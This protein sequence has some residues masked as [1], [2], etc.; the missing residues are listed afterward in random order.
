M[1]DVGHVQFYNMTS[2]TMTIT[3]NSGN[4]KINL[5]PKDQKAPAYTPA[6]SGETIARSTNPEPYQQA[7]F[8]IKN[9]I[10]W[11]LSGQG[12]TKDITIAVELDQSRVNRDIQVYMF[13]ASAVVVLDNDSATFYASPD[14]GPVNA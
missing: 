4:D 1:S 12:A 10:S 3:L 7:I 6:N 11:L 2:Q 8:G 5:E 14:K 9:K 13:Y